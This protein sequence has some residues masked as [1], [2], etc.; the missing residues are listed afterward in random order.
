[1][2][3]VRAA[4]FSSSID[5]QRVDAFLNRNKRCGLCPPDLLKFGELLEESDEK[6][7]EQIDGNTQHVLYDLLPPPSTALQ[8]YDLRQRAVPSTRLRSPGNYW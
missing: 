1:M 4:G 3:L 8:T 7:F 6:L 5:R 2:L